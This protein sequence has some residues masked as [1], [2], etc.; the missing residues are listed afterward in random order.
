MNGFSTLVFWKI[1]SIRKE[2]YDFSAENSCAA[3]F[4]LIT[5]FLTPDT[6]SRRTLPD[7]ESD[8]QD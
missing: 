8:F 5:H 2:H 3:F 6:P 7:F 1:F 4:L